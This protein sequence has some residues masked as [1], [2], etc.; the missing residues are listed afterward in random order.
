MDDIHKDE[1]CDCVSYCI[2]SVNAERRK[3]RLQ[4]GRDFN[5]K[6]MCEHNSPP[7]MHRADFPAILQKTIK[8]G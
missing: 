7:R 8:H 4:E 3:R 1:C 2:C 6:Y 5:L